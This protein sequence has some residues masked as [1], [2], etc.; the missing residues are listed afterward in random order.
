MP[1]P[2]GNTNATKGKRWS[3]AIDRALAKRCLGNGIKALDD[4]AEVLLKEAEAGDIS[5]LKELGDRLEG[6]PHQTIGGQDGED[7][8]LSLTVKYVKPS[9]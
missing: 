6:R 8:P 7:I 2:L 1:A 3:Q 4:L 5:A 9:D